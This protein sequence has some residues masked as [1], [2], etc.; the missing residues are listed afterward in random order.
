MNGPK[1]APCRSAPRIKIRSIQIAYL[2]FPTGNSGIVLD[3]STDGLGF[4]V[5]EPLRVN[6]F[7]SL[8]LSAPGFRPFSLSARVTWLDGTHR[9]GGLRVIVPVDQRQMYQSWQQQLRDFLSEPKP[10]ISNARDPEIPS[11][12]PPAKESRISRN[13]L[14]GCLILILSLSAFVGSD[15]MGAARR[16][17]D[18]LKHHS[19]SGAHSL[20]SATTNSQ[21]AAPLSRDAPQ[22]AGQGVASSRSRSRTPGNRHANRFDAQS[23]G[24]ILSPITADKQQH[25]ADVSGS[26][27]G[28]VMLPSTARVIAK[29]STREANGTMAEQLSVPDSVAGSS[30]APPVSELQ[31]QPRATAVPLDARDVNASRTVAST[32][33]A[34]AKPQVSTNGNSRRAAAAIAATAPLARTAQIPDALESKPPGPAADLE[35]C[36][37][38]HSVPPVYPSDARRQ[39]VEGE[40]K[41]RVVVGADGN[42][43]SAVSLGG[44]PL[45]VPAAV[46]A[47]LQFHYQPARLNGE[48][49][50][51]VQTIEIAFELKR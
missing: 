14:A 45:L 22:S 17:G 1:T 19:T 35:P 18:L 24:P 5:V 44:P 23:P 21:N 29:P 36:H 3:V 26:M 51:T 15:L 40:V 6:D 30:N 49:I 16:I 7:F 38:I 32:G 43:R 46:S 42:V 31:R 13:V 2:N 10:P 37:L 33:G 11:Q 12:A 34:A 8:R 4:Q 39:R 50:E 48:P 9:R 28:T 25:P 27:P 41:L 47:T 20:A